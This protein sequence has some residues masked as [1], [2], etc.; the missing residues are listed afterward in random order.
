MF[1]PFNEIPKNATLVQMDMVVDP[2]DRTFTLNVTAPLKV[3]NRVFDAIGS[4][5]FKQQMSDGLSATAVASR[6]GTYENHLG[7][8]C[9]RG[10]YFTACIHSSH[11]ELGYLGPAVARSITAKI[12][13]IYPGSISGGMVHFNDSKATCAQDVLDLLDKTRLGLEE[14]GL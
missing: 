6:D 10:A 14:K 12:R 1:N 11:A 9:L 2:E 8:V 7:Q 4:D 3:M 13:E 5:A